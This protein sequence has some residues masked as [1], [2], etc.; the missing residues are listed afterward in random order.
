MVNR[1]FYSPLLKLEVRLSIP[2]LW[3]YSEMEVDGGRTRISKWKW[4]F[5]GLG[6]GGRFKGQKD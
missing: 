4:I 5:V 1:P 2:I 3:R 6:S